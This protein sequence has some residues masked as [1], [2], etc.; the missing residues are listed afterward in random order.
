MHKFAPLLYPIC[1]LLHVSA[2][3]CHHQ[4]ASWIRL[5]LRE[6]LN[7]LCGISYN[8]WLCGPCAGAA[9]DRLLCFPSRVSWEAPQT[10]PRH[11]DTQAT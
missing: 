9:W 7:K 1:R 8:V 6:M 2:V 5:E 10:E 4:G 11:S 3:V